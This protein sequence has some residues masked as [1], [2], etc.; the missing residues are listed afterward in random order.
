[1]NFFDKHRGLKT[2]LPAFVFVAAVILF[3]NALNMIPEFATAIAKM[4]DILSPFIWGF[5]IAFILYIPAGKFEHFLLKNRYSFLS[6]HARAFAVLVTYLA[7]ISI[8]GLAIAFIVPKIAASV[9]DLVNQVPAYY[10][11]L[12]EF[13]EQYL[14]ADGKLFGFDVIAMKDMI[15]PSK[16]LS[17]FDFTSISKYAQGVYKFGGALIDVFL[18][19]VISVYM[20]LGRD[21]LIRTCGVVLSLAIPKKVLKTCYS[22]I[23][24]MSDIFYSY[25]YSQLLDCLIVG[26]LLSIVF[27]FLGLK[28]AFLLAMLIGVCNLIPYFGATISGAVVALLTLL[29]SNWLTA[30]LTLASIIIIQQIDANILQPKIVGTTVGIR[31]I[32]VLLAITVGGGLF[33]FVGILIGVP[34][35]ATIRMIIIDIISCRGNK[36]SKGTK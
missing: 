30:V 31:P 25:I 3:N 16:I 10:D 8:V 9:V 2:W 32:Y 20:L 7:F 33:G 36:P 29:S 11:S 34:I 4:L 6:K 12:L 27:A 24:R 23:K 5:V 26:I 28:Y 14:D 1:M 13:L 17:F 21:Y 18:A 19:F 35:I 15:T 22:Y